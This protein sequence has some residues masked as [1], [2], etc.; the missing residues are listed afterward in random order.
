MHAR[1]K[2]SFLI[3]KKKKYFQQL[4]HKKY[5]NNNIKLKK[6][7]FNKCNYILTKNP[8]YYKNEVVKNKTLKIKNKSFLK[9]IQKKALFIKHYDYNLNYKSIMVTY[10]IKNKINITKFNK[11]GYFLK[12]QNK[13]LAIIK[14]TFNTSL[15]K[16]II[17]KKNNIFNLIKSELNYYYGFL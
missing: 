1:T 11:R 16:L 12:K 9:L 17:I 6:I 13:K 2:L 7:F 10:N 15:I 14:N 3:I 5:F 4:K 8:M